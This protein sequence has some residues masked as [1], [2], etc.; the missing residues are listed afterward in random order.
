MDAVF[1]DPLA[2]SPGSMTRRELLAGASISALAACS[3]PRRSDSTVTVLYKGQPETVLGPDDWV[4]KFLVFMPLAA[5]NSRDGRSTLEGRLAESWEHSADFR[6]WTI[7][8]RDGVRWHDGVPVTAHDMKFTLDLLQ[9]PDTLQFAQ[10]GYTVHVLDDLTYTVTYHRKDP[11]D[12]EPVSDWTVCWPK[13]V[14]ERLDPKQINT[15]DFWT[16][17]VGCGPYRHVHTVPKTMMEFE[18]NADYFRGRP[19][20]RRVILKFGESNAVPELLSRNVDAVVSPR[21]TDL[22]NIS[23]YSGFRAHQ[24]IARNGYAAFWNVRHSL[25]QDPAVRRALTYAINRRELIEILKLP[26]GTQPV[27]FVRTDRQAR[28]G[29]YPETHPYDPQTADRILDRAGWRRQGKGLRSRAGRPFRFRA[30]VQGALMESTVPAV[31]IQDQLRRIGVQMDIV[32]ISD[33]SLISSRIKS[34]EF[35]AV[36]ANGAGWE[37]EAVLRGTGYDN[38]AFFDLF[39]RTRVVFDPEAKEE[40]HDEMRRIF[41]GDLPMTYLFPFAGTTI[42]STRIRGLENSPYREDPTWCM[43][44][45]WLEQDET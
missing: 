23:G 39:S 34:G 14:L 36:L 31:Y 2:S 29:D 4:A 38:R 21:R 18:A 12:D 42:A 35:E 11:N 40:L 26:E 9:N 37:Q 28:R 1:T 22:F 24:Q 19:K 33:D 15:W 6:T 20:I 32:T 13:H 30:L 27:D 45:L 43:D 25:F 7:R 41:R 44:Q 17:P 8:L 10:G 3:K 5:W 16:H